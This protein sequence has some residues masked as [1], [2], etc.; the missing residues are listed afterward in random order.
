L[1]KILFYGFLIKVGDWYHIKLAHYHKT[2]LTFWIVLYKLHGNSFLHFLH[3]SNPFE[4]F[5]KWIFFK[6][7]WFFHLFF[8]FFNGFLIEWNSFLPYWT[9]NA[10]E[11]KNQIFCFS[12]RSPLMNCYVF[13]LKLNQLIYSMDLNDFEWIWI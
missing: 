11:L 12:K 9:L 10:T 4:T 3:F 2:S 7:K 13:Q 8:K 6:F 1:Y 5:L